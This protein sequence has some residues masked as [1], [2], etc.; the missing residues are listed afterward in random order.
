M[1]MIELHDGALLDT[2]HVSMLERLRGD[3][4]LSGGKCESHMPI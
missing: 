3:V 4:A 2:A 1:K